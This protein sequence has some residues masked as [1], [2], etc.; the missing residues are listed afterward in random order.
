MNTVK[1][2][3]TKCEIKKNY[4]IMYFRKANKHP[5]GCMV[6][7]VDYEKQEVKFAVAQHN[8]K[9]DYKKSFGRD[10]AILRL[11]KK[12]RTFSFNSKNPSYKDILHDLMHNIVVD[13]TVPEKI[14]AA[15]DRFVKRP[16]LNLEYSFKKPSLK[17]LLHD[18]NLCLGSSTELP[19]VLRY[20]I[21]KE[22][23]NLVEGK[24]QGKVKLKMADSK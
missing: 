18:L 14:R 20:G 10:V 23:E 11:E 4:K 16:T 15:A 5:V 12:P 9:E 6:Y 3:H 22:F 17:A 19:K 2:K 8:S 1:K 13:L 7:I 24:S 21:K